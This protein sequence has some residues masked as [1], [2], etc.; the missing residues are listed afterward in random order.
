MKSINIKITIALL[1]SILVAFSSCK[2]DDPVLEDDQEEYDK[3]EIIFTSLED[4][5]DVQT[6]NFN[7]TGG[8]ESSSY[9]LFNEK[10]YAI[11]INIFQD[12]ELINQEFIDEADEHKFFFLAPSDAVINYIYKDDDLGLT[13]E[14]SFGESTSEF[15]LTILLRHGLDKA[16]PAAQN[17]NS[18]T[19]HQ[20]NGVD[21]LRLEIPIL[22]V[23]NNH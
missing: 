14:I 6:I 20:A 11:Q 15:N 16:H 4:P 3:I 17:W 13:G 23:V 5:N 2:R 18:R 8:I 7:K 12:E 19:Y 10:N 21:D 22:L 9:Q 1:L